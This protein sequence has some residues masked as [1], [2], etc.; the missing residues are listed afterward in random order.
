MCLSCEQALS[1]GGGAKGEKCSPFPPSGPHPP[2]E[3]ARRLECAK[4]G[5]SKNYLT[6][7]CNVFWVYICKVSQNSRIPLKK[8]Q[9]TKQQKKKT[10]S[11]R[12]FLIR[13]LFIWRK[14]CYCQKINLTSKAYVTYLSK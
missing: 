12:L 13:P 4:T 14:Q 7:Q 5:H 2:R 8:N 1:R 6:M 3:L 10:H 11:I 9:Q